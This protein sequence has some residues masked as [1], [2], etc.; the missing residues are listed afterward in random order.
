VYI[1]LILEMCFYKLH[2][3]CK[4]KQRTLTYYGYVKFSELQ[5]TATELL[6]LKKFRLKKKNGNM[7]RHT[8]F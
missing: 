8:L 1:R 6:L 4:Q 3:Q 2:K 7:W 5:H